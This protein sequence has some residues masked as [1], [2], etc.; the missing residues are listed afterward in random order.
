MTDEKPTVEVRT[1]LLG[2]TDGLM[3]TDGDVLTIKVVADTDAPAHRH[4]G[5]PYRWQLV[6]HRQ[7]DG[8]PA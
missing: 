2:D 8:R 4:R 3:V 1:V 6:E 7:A 5:Y